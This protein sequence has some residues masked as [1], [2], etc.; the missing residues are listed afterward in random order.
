MGKVSSSLT[1]SSVSLMRALQQL[2]LLNSSFVVAD[3]PTL[4]RTIFNDCVKSWITFAE[5]I[6]KN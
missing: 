3:A 1:L 4:Q 5:D 6:V 2:M